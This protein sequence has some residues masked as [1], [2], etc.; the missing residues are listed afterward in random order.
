[1]KKRLTPSEAIKQECRYCMNFQKIKCESEIC[2]L[3]NKNL[4]P[5]R[6]IKEHCLECHPDHSTQGAR[7]CDGIVLYPEYHICPLHIYRL[8]KNPYLKGAKSV[9][10]LKEY[11]FS[12]V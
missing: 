6:R 11:Q 3:R 5:L 8:G 7:S 2:K 12:S 4:T 1:M 10:H 9:E